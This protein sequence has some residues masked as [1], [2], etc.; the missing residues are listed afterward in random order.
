[1]KINSLVMRIY[2]HVM[3]IYSHDVKKVIDNELFLFRQ[4]VKSIMSLLS[5]KFQGS[6][7]AEWMLIAN[8]YVTLRLYAD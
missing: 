5:S 4:L 7:E 2:S 6:I 8:D 3:K 1:M